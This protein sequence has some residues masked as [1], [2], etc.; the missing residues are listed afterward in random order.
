MA[1]STMA[2]SSTSTSGKS[3]EWLTPPPRMTVPAASMELTKMP[4][5]PEVAPGT[6]RA[7]GY[8][9]W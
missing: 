8:W 6:V 7:G 2:P 5:L 4:S 9:P 1:S 3:T